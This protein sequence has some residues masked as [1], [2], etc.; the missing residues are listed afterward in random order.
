MA[1]AKLKLLG[2]G[3]PPYEIVQL[4]D[5]PPLPNDNQYRDNLLINRNRPFKFTYEEFKVK[6]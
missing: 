4:Y 1:A 3:N 2:E 5:D 6:Y